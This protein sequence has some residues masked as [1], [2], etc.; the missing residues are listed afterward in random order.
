MPKLWSFQGMHAHVIPLI[1]QFRLFYLNLHVHLN[2]EFV[3]SVLGH[4]SLI[5]FVDFNYF[6]LPPKQHIVPARKLSYLASNII[7]MM[8]A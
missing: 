6:S 1:R 3:T 4:L 5:S 8:S 7:Q 2:G